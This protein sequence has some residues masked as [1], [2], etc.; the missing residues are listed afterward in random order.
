MVIT[1][2]TTI[3]NIIVIWHC[4]TGFYD[5]TSVCI[6]VYNDI[7]CTDLNVELNLVAVVGIVVD[8]LKTFTIIALA[9]IR[10]IRIECIIGY[11]IQANNRLVRI[12]HD[13]VFAILLLHNQVN[14]AT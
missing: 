11:V 4:L 6:C 12:L 14:D 2:A 9:I 8:L 10:I 1:D 7:K 3:N 13:Q 5:Y